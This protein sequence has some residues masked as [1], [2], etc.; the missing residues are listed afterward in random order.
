MNADLMIAAP[1]HS[2]SNNRWDTAQ[3]TE[4]RGRHREPHQQTGAGTGRRPRATN[5]TPRRQVD[6]EAGIRAQLTKNRP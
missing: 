6:V 1:N 2:P 3:G 4:Q 5:L